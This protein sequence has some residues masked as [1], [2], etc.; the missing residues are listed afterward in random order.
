MAWTP[1]DIPDQSGRVAVVTGA[2]GGLGLEAARELARNGAHVVMAARNLDKAAE[3]ERDIRTGNADA[4]VETVK[5]DLSS[6]ESVKRAAAQ[7][8]AA[9]PRI[10]ILIN[11]AGVMATPE[12]RTEDGFELQLA[13]NHLGHFTLTAGLL[14]ALLAAP[15]ARVVSVT[16]TARHM[17][18]PV[19]PDNPHLHGRYE[20]WRAYGQSKLANLHFAIELHRRL[21]AAGAT[22]ASLVA[23]PGLSNTDLQASSVVNTGRPTQRI[24]HVAARYIGMP[25]ARGAHPQLRAAT[26]PGARSGELYAP[27]F[28]NNGPAVRRPLF[29]RS[30]R[31]QDTRLLW[32]VSERETGVKFDVAAAARDASP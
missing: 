6:Q 19:D 3:A 7:I 31:P 11:N 17:G 10:D 14:P 29:A 22:A 12:S 27:R 21:A 18:R 15:Q 32:E 23:H 26:D 28:V 9:H 25:A 20:P 13:T 24:A 1:D 8:R 30:V 4:L 2:N 5:L 16:S